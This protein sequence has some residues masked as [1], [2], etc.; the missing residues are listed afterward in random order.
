MSTLKVDT[1]QDTSGSNQSTASEIRSGRAK[2]WVEFSGQGGATIIGSFGVSSVARRSNGNYT[3]NFSS[4]FV[5][6]N[7]V[8]LATSGANVDSYANGLDGIDNVA[9]VLNKF[10][11]KVFVGAGD[12]D[13]GL[14]DDMDR[15]SV[16]I[17]A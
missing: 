1:I 4:N 15:I 16:A 5:D 11:D 10:V 13:D 2:I 3:V 9:I 14:N 7:Y 12:L 6:T 8:V 17:F